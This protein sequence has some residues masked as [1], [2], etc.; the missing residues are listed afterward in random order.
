VGCAKR[1][2][3]RDKKEGVQRCGEENHTGRINLQ[4]PPGGVEKKKFA[5]K[6]DRKTQEAKEAE[7]GECTK[8]VENPNFCN[9]KHYTSNS[10][11]VGTS[12]NIPEGMRGKKRIEE[13]KKL[14]HGTQQKNKKDVTG[15]LKKGE[16]GRRFPVPIYRIGGRKGR[17][18]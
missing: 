10:Q 9:Q 16:K 11:W 7:D 1:V 6:K 13:E 18:K 5:L 8:E 12:K 3:S 4:T 17:K 15:K 2:K 14:T